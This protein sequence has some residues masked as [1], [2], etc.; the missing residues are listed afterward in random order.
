[1]TWWVHKDN[2][3]DVLFASGRM[4]GRCGMHGTGWHGGW[5]QGHLPRGNG[6]ALR[7]TASCMW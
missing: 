1:M 7:S 6:R 5:G 2:R 4:A 3:F